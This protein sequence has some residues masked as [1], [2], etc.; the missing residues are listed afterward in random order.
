L[1]YVLGTE[2]PKGIPLSKLSL[3]E[4]KKAL[5]EN[6]VVSHEKVQSWPGCPTGIS[7]LDN[8]LLWKG[9]PKGAL[10]LIRGDVGLGGTQLWLQAGKKLTEAGKWIAWI[11]GRDS[12]LY[13]CGARRLRLDRTLW[14]SSPVDLKQKLWAIQ[15]VGSL[16]LFDLVGFGLREGLGGEVL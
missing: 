11:N 4:L 6:A 15:E 8:F 7:A 14:I 1:N 16:C 13:A 2:S 10:T 3:A 5:G 12:E 9:F